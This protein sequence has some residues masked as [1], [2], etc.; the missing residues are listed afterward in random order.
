MDTGETREEAVPP[1]RVAVSQVPEV[2]AGA[3]GD[4]DRVERMS[5][6]EI[7]QELQDRNISARGLVEK[8]ELVDALRLARAA[9]LQ[10]LAQ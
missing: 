3:A 9:D 6:A 8:R 2:P 4:G 10:V 7:K 1:K 5:V